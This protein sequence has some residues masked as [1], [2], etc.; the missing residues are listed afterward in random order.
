MVILV[1]GEWLVSKGLW[2]LYKFTLIKA[3]AN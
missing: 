1:N 3:T 2:K